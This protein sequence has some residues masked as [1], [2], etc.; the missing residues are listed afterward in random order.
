MN[1]HRRI[2]A[3][4]LQLAKGADELAVSNQRMIVESE[5]MKSGADL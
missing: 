1:D 5:S 4:K 3:I 2:A